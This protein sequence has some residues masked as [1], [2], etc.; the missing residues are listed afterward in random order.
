[1]ALSG[2][3]AIGRFEGIDLIL[4]CAWIALASGLR[5]S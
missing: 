5:A 3:C 1:M 2:L 4:G